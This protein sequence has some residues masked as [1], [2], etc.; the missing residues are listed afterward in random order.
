VI[1]KDG[2]TEQKVAAAAGPDRRKPSPQASAWAA[3]VSLS[4]GVADG[5][6][7]IVL[8]A[9][10]GDLLLI[11]GPVTMCWW[12]SAVAPAV[13][14]E[15]PENLDLTRRSGRVRLEKVSV[16]GDDVLSGS[17]GNRPW[18]AP[19]RCWPLRRSVGAADC[20]DSAVEYAKVASAV[21]PNHRHVPGDQAPLRQHAGRLGV[22]HRRG[23][24]TPPGRIPRMRSSSALRRLRLRH[25][26]FPAYAGNAELNI[27]VH[28]GIGFTWEHDA[29]LHLRRAL[30]TTALFGGDAPADDVFEAHRR[31][32][33][34]GK[35]S[36]DLPPEAE[37]M[38]TRIHAEVAELA[39]LDK[40][41]QRDKADRN[42][43]RDAALA[44]AMG[45]GR[46]CGGAVGDRGGVPRSGHQTHR[47][48]H[49]RLG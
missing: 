41:A 44:Q 32:C 11:A 7:G 37:E 16:S 24:G 38:R 49:H 19:G 34:S 25:W 5:E 15:V 31:W 42:R 9:G 20:V 39:A 1:A 40:Q 33:R 8:G 21:R 10:L 30:V 29:H 47:L 13:T 12:W 28:G 46:R 43:L 2:S 6:A 35:N 36:L 45:T 17:A 4:N 14:V 23:V 48:W 26:R 3:N 27:Q 22:G 18:H